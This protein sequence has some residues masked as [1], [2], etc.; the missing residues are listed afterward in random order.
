MFKILCHLQQ[1]NEQCF[2]RCHRGQRS[3]RAV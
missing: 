2:H 3:R 1:S